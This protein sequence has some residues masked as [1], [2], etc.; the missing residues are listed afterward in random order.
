MLTQFDDDGQEFMMNF[1]LWHYRLFVHNIER[2]KWEDNCLLQLWINGWIQMMCCVEQWED[3]EWHVHK[4]LDYFG[5]LQL[6]PITYLLVVKD[7]IISSTIYFSMC[8][9]LLDINVV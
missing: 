6:V 8:S 1:V 9:V 5:V 3:I 4:E 7:A 2:F